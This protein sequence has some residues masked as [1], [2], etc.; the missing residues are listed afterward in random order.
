MISQLVK[1]LKGMGKSEA[2]DLCQS[3]SG[4]CRSSGTL[5]LDPGRAT[6][7]A[8]HRSAQLPVRAEQN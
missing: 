3:S 2:E 1:V 7:E 6:V 4:A 5:P 8:K